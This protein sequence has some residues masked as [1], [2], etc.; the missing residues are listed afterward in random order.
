MLLR[1]QRLRYTVE[2]QKRFDFTQLTARA[3]FGRTKFFQ[4]GGCVFCMM[5][6]RFFN[7]S[8]FFFHTEVVC[9]KKAL[10]RHYTFSLLLSFFVTL[11]VLITTTPAAIKNVLPANPLFPRHQRRQTAMLLFATRDERTRGQRRI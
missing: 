5:K 4:A 11:V 1:M 2:R 8:V 7:S 9:L 6:K 3:F 10:Q